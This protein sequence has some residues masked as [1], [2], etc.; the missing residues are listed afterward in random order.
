VVQKNR[1][2][3]FLGIWEQIHNPDFNYGHQSAEKI[4][5]TIWK[6]HWGYNGYRNLKGC[7]EIVDW[8][9][10]KKWV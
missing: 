3:G 10:S 4:L 2:V 7:K 9:H 8:F 6:L 5:T 1:G